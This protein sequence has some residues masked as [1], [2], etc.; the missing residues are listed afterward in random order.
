MVVK[1]NEREAS[2]RMERL[3]QCNTVEEEQN[4]SMV[5]EERASTKSQKLLYILAAPLQHR[6]RAIERN[7]F[8]V[9]VSEERAAAGSTF[10]Q[11]VN[12]VVWTY[13]KRTFDEHDKRERTVSIVF[14]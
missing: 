8:W 3:Q 13:V 7:L 14:I 10:A 2:Y 12:L 1:I 6:R 5:A 11:V 4:A 9:V